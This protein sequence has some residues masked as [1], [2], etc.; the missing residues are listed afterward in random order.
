M[1]RV[2][3]VV[4]AGEDAG[5]RA[6]LGTRDRLIVVG[7][8]MFAERGFKGTTIGQ[9]E[10]AAGLSPRRG[11]AY[12]HFRDKRQLF[13]A[14]VERHIHELQ[15][16]S[17]VMDLLPLGDPRSETMLL[18]RW[19]LQQLDH[20]RPVVAVLEKE[21]EAFPDLRDRFYREVIDV[22]YRRTAA[23]IRR[24]GI[25]DVELDLDVLTAVFV[26]AMVDRR[27]TRW[28]FGEVPLD[29]DEERFVNGLVDMVMALWAQLSA[30]PSR[31]S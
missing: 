13:E 12:R 28:T 7:M 3:R 15:S 24:Y 4:G 11:A 9:I 6:E 5:S 25:S 16:M 22:G 30:P 10:A 8:A 18:V 27:R 29:L 1:P 31:R 14:A 2:V 19:F 23:L 17:G 26:G 21:G 20:Q